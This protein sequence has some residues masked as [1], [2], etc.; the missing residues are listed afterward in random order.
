[1]HKYMKE[2]IKLAQ[3]AAS[4]GEIPVGAVVVRRVTGEIVGRGY[5]RRETDKNA[6]A[7]AEVMAI[8]DAC[9]NLGGWRLPGCDLY[10]TLEPCP[11]CCGAIINSRIER[12]IYGADDTKAGSVMSV[13]NMFSLPYNH[14]PEIFPGI[15]AEECAGLLTAFFK[16]IRKIQKHFGGNMVNLGNEWD[17]LL[18]DEFKKDYY[19][20]LRKILIKEY[21]TQTIYPDMYDL[22]NAL[23]YTSYSDVKAVIIGQ[24][25]YHGAGQA[26]G[27][28]FSVQKGVMPPPSLKNIFKEIQS[29]LGIDNSGKHGELTSWAKSGVLLLNAVLSV[30]EATPN[31]HKNIGWEQFTDKIISLLNERETP[32]VFI[33]WGANAKAKANLIT[34]KRHLILTAAHPSP[35]SAHNGFFGCKHFSKTNEF[36]ASNNIVPIDW[37]ID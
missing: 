3:Y 36:L 10:V 25:P 34:N 28:S 11:M 31:S 19:T 7:H 14:R 2:A 20:N 5:N 32:V 22:F 17:N 24:D 12:V 30:R 1:M 27:L 18:A 33:L 23:K 9:K 4:I 8:N 26:H 15:M 21:K 35:L 6:L 29:D 13:Q 16:N 37:S